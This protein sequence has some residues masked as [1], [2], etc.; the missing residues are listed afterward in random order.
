MI[1]SGALGYNFSM[2]IFW[3]FVATPLARWLLEMDCHRTPTSFHD[4]RAGLRVV[5]LAVLVDQCATTKRIRKDT[6]P[7]AL[8]SLSE[9]DKKS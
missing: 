9:S 8:D 6:Y 3:G 5:V 2:C 7:T 4:R 1:S